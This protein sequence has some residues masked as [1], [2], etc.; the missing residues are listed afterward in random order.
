MLLPSGSAALYRRAMLEQIGGFDEDFFLYCEDTDLGLRAHW[1]G[2]EMRVCARRRGR[3]SLLAFGRARLAAESLL[4]G[5]KPASRGHQEFSALDAGRGAAALG[6]ALRL[7]SAHSVSG[8]GAAGE[9]RKAG[10][11]PFHAGHGSVA[12]SARFGRCG[13]CLAYSPRGAAYHR[14]IPAAR[15]VALARQH[16]LT[17]REVAKL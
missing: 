10:G 12:Q 4:C 7:A 17:A 5:A 3:P 15:F 1:A 9:F 8:R 6:A 2:M 11:S 14:A 16:S 13:S